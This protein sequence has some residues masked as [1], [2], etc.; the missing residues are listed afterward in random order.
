[1]LSVDKEAEQ[2]SVTKPLHTFIMELELNI[3][4]VSD[5][6]YFQ[7]DKFQEGTERYGLLENKRFHNGITK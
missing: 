2:K 7:K 5:L 3:P 4:F 6:P 1:M